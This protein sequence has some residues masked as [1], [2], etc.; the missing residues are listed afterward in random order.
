MASL[1]KSARLFVCCASLVIGSWCAQAKETR[2]LAQNGK[3]KN[4]GLMVGVSHGLPG[5]DL[6]VD[7]AT[8]M[9]SNAAYQ[10]STLRLMDSQGTSDRIARELTQQSKLV[11]AEGTFFFYYSGHGSPG[12]LYVQDGLMEVDVIREAIK[13]G[14]DGLAPLARLVLVFDSC[15]SGSL[16]DPFRGV[17]DFNFTD[18][19]TATKELVDNVTSAFQADGERGNYWSSLFV[20]ASSRADET[21]LAGSN[22]S[23]F[24]V[25]MKKA[26]DEA[27][28]AKATMGAFV[29]KAKTYTEGHHPVE[30][31]VP[32]KLASEPMLP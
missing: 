19:A 22:G 3:A 29:E 27:L 30:R 16:L 15:F 21:S 20:F 24:T 31:F 23:V 13:T 25:A 17:L 18:D 32:A 8:A 26:F 6:D 11:D 10:F 28:A 1:L 4:Y 14:R 2:G 5:I 7:M 12:S 9:A